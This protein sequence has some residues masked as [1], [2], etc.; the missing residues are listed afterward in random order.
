MP[1]KSLYVCLEFRDC[2]AQ[3]LLTVFLICWRYS[4]WVRPCNVHCRISLRQ[5]SCVGRDTN[6]LC[7]F[8][9]RLLGLLSVAARP[10]L[11]LR[12]VCDS[13]AISETPEIVAQIVSIPYSGMISDRAIESSPPHSSKRPSVSV[14]VGGIRS[15]EVAS[16][17]PLITAVADVARPNTVQRR[18]R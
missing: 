2:Y 7:P 8:R 16:L 18:G 1:W 17:H 10:T 6:T 3:L 15:N 11:S 14:V 9:I 12:L 4:F 5:P 13:G